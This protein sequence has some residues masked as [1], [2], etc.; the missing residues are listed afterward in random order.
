MIKRGLVTMLAAVLAFAHA[1]PP[2]HADVADIGTVVRE[3]QPYE[4]RFPD[5]LQLA[6]GRL[7]AVWHRATLHVGND[8]DDALGTIQMSTM[9]PN[10][11][12]GWS[13]PV[14]ALARPGFLG[15]VD[16]RDPKLALMSDG[17]VI[18]T[19]FTQGKVYY[20]YWRPTWT[21]FTDP[22][23]L[24]VLGAAPT[25][26]SHGSV[27]PVTSGGVPTGEVLIPFYSGGPSGGAYYLRATYHPNSLERLKPF[28]VKRIIANDEPSGYRYTEPS[29][30]QI[31]DTI[32]AA[33]RAEETLVTPP[34]GQTGNH[35]RALVVARWDA[36]DDSTAATL[37]RV[38]LG[39][40]PLLASSHHL[41]KTRQGKILLTYGNRYVYT[42][43]PTYG[44]LIED[45]L[46]PWTGTPRLLYDSGAYDQANPSSVEPA[47]GW[48]WTLGFDAHPNSRTVGRL[49]MIRSRPSDYQP[50]PE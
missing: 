47:E 23:P 5:I 27:L 38:H 14:P 40:E 15:Q 9:T 50:Q 39:G 1:P 28:A 12:S 36:H 45:P 2:A 37:E 35:A 34:P 3:P 20:S 46:A 24:D 13:A 19:F 11:G 6:D 48:F 43:R 7:M 16:M 31:G 44:M 10:S 32:V 26:A 21:R 29:F 49:L 42:R 41:L 17:Q 33:V 4:A 22:R 8:T 30:V 25:A 18:L